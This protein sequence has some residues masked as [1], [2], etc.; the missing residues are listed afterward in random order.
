[1]P[2]IGEWFYASYVHSV[3][4]ITTL[5]HNIQHALASRLHNNPRLQGLQAKARDV[6]HLLIGILCCPA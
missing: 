2:Q 1:M 6:T 5:L 3:L 4:V